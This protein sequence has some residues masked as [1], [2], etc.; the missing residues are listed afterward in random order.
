M[1][2]F[3]GTETIHDGRYYVFQSDDCL[4]KYP[5]V[6][7]ILG[8]TSDDTW[9]EEWRNRIGK[10]K[11]DQISKFSA[12]RGS[13]MHLFCEYFMDDHYT[14]KKV[15]DLKKVLKRGYDNSRKDGY[16]EDEIN[17]GRNLFYNFY[18]SGTF[19][20]VKRVIVQ[21]KAL[22]NK[23][24]GG[25]A[26]RVDFIYVDILNHLIIGDF[27]TSRKPKYEESIENYKMQISAYYMAFKE[28]TG[29]SANHGEIWIS[30]EQNNNPQ[31]FTI[32]NIEI[33]KYFDMFLDRVREY[34]SMFP[35]EDI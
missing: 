20:R 29:H 30:N 11:A 7:T 18:N 10:E 24:E 35:I 3:K 23:I 21:E 4:F 1:D 34:H 25:Y 31:I 5:S 12:N 17:V 27:K 19:N 9:L 8:K 13:V 14:G 16:S 2:I 28:M 32:T 33:K 15:K 26:G 6:T 22:Y